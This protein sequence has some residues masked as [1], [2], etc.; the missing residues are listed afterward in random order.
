MARILIIDNESA[1]PNML[2]AGFEIMGFE[3]EV[4]EASGRNDGLKI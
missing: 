1:A 3:V 4:I 2:R